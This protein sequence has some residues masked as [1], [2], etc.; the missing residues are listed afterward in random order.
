MYIAWKKQINDLL[1]INS[2]KSNQIKIGVN[3]IRV[4]DSEMSIRIHT[5]EE[6]NSER[7][8]F[9]SVKKKRGWRS[10]TGKFNISEGVKVKS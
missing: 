9:L 10:E 2:Y 4:N 5:K 7:D 8:G 1:F 3:E 6:K